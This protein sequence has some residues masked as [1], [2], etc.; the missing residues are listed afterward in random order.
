MRIDWLDLP[1]L[2]TLTTTETRYGAYSY[3]FCFPHHITLESDSHPLWMMFRHA[4]SHRCGSSKGIRVQ[5]WRHNHRKYSLHPSLTNRHR[6]SSTQIQLITR[7]CTIWIS[8][9]HTHHPHPPIE[10]RV[11]WEGIRLQ[12][13][14]SADCS[15]IS[16]WVDYR[17]GNYPDLLQSLWLC[18]KEKNQ[19]L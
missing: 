8:L 7:I 11:I 6:S 14:E 18:G 9:F 12:W 4:Q 13:M 10:Y 16:L 5:G 19:Q 2:K 17:I 1:K 3:T 15:P